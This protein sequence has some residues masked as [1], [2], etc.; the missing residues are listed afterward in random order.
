MHK[1][2][3]PKFRVELITIKADGFIKRCDDYDYDY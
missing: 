1:L 3:A 2:S